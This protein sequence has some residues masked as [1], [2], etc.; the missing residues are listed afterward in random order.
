M[1]HKP[2]IGAIFGIVSEDGVA[3]QSFPVNLYDR[4]DGAHV[5]R[6]VTDENGG[7]VFNGLNADTNDYQVVAQDEDNPPYKNAIIRDRIQ[8]VPGYQGANYWGNWRKLAFDLGAEVL[9]DGSTDEDGNLVPPYCASA[10]PTCRGAGG[11]NIVKPV[12]APSITPGAPDIPG[13]DM[14]GTKL[15]VRQRQTRYSAAD[16]VD[17]LHQNPTSL[18]FEFVADFDNLK[19][20]GESQGRVEWGLSGCRDDRAVE[21]E[22]GYYYSY[23]IYASFDSSTKEITLFRNNGNGSQSNWRS[24]LSSLTPDN[25]TPTLSGVCHCVVVINYGLEAFLYVNG[26]QVAHY[27]LAG[28]NSYWGMYNSDTYGRNIFVGIIGYEG[29]SNANYYYGCN[30]IDGTLGPC[31]AYPFDLTAENVSDLYNALMVGVTPKATGYMREVLIDRPAFYARLCDP[32]GTTDT[33]RTELRPS[34]LYAGYTSGTVTWQQPSGVAGGNGA[35][36]DGASN[37]RFDSDGAAQFSQYGYVMEFIM[38]PSNALPA[39]EETLFMASNTSE[40]RTGIQ[41]TR[42]VAGKINVTHS[43]SGAENF[44]FAH[45]FD[46]T[47]APHHVAV[48]V[49]KQAFEATLFIDGTSVETVSLTT[50]LLDYEVNTDMSTYWHT[51]VGGVAEDSGVIAPE[52]A[53]AGMMA[54]VAFYSAALSDEAIKRHA[55][56]RSTP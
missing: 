30:G 12:F 3:K 49:D 22:S 16:A 7:F 11:T 2:G 38:Q 23:P 24:Y 14:N 13:L 36:F 53:F 26:E 25:E 21:T 9:F 34:D 1:P 27:A 29:S 31:A 35:L 28:T 45:V 43:A 32:A 33:V 6:Q 40:N 48:R 5:S 41:V 10:V 39:A 42:D 37:I 4:T 56:A 47:E 55:D 50:S 51:H 54:E 17:K 46:D 18:S 15:A 20:A 8:P 52:G 44:Y 19:P